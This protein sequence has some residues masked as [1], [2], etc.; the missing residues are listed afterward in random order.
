MH[1]LPQL[2]L[3]VPYVHVEIAHKRSQLK[4][5]Y[6]RFVAIEWHIIT[7][8]LMISFRTRKTAQGFCRVIPALNGATFRYFMLVGFS[9]S[10]LYSGFCQ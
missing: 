1:V 5:V 9:K 7:S 10:P 2:A 6:T 3:T 4:S 8:E